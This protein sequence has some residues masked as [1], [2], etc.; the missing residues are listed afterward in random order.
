VGPSH[1][2]TGY[3]G[4]PFSRGRTSDPLVRTYLPLSCYCLYRFPTPPFHFCLPPPPPAPPPQTS[5]GAFSAPSAI[6]FFLTATSDEGSPPSPKMGQWTR[7]ISFFPTFS[8][9][10]ERLL[11]AEASYFPLLVICPPSHFLSNSLSKAPS[12]PSTIARPI[13]SFLTQTVC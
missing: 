13:S 8:P 2:L 12:S 7:R 1:L 3:P 11:F 10:N 4:A 6:F 9:A 5:D